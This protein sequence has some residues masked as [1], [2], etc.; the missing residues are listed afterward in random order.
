MSL[1]IPRHVYADLYGP[2]KGDR[3]RLADTDLIVEV[4]NTGGSFQVADVRVARAPAASL[5]DVLPGLLTPVVD[6]SALHKRLLDRTGDEI[7]LDEVL[8]RD[9]DGNSDDPQRRPGA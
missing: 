6:T 1:T 7:T 3:V 2:T 8:R 5:R 4:G 9:I